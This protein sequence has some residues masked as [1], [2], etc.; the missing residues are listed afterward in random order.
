M[1]LNEI[2]LEPLLDTLRLEKI[3]DNVYFS[4]PIY[5]NRISN[6]RL[7]L[8]NPKQGGSPEK[9]FGGFKSTFNPSFALGK[10]IA[11]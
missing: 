4:S 6:S 8:L 11:A 9:F 3:N 7:G 1:K 2:K 10:I 5:K